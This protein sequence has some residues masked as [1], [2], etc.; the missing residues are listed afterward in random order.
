MDECVTHWV[1]VRKKPEFLRR[2]MDELAGETRI[3]FEGDLS[4]CNFATDLIVSQDEI[5]VL[6]RNTL[7]PRQ[8]F[9]VLRMEPDTVSQIYKQ[10]IVAGLSR[11]ILH[12]QIERAGTTQLGAY[13][14]FHPECVVVGP[15]VST[16]ML[17]ALK[18]EGIIRDFVVAKKGRS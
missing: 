7:S 10:V 6:R 14:N 16:A 12:V 2:L 9:V 4:R 17:S 1:N 5:G 11:A 18:S 3:A 8:D 15:G 13:D